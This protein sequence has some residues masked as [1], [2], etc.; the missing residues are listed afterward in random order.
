[1]LGIIFDIVFWLK[2]LSL[3]QWYTSR[4]IKNP[5]SYLFWEKKV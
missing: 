5:G 1:M 4:G 3:K 2:H